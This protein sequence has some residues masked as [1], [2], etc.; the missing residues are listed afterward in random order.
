MNKDEA[1]AAAIAESNRTGQPAK[2]IISTPWQVTAGID[3]DHVQTLGRYS[4]CSTTAAIV[5]PGNPGQHAVELRQQPMGRVAHPREVA[6]AVAFLLSEEASF[7]TATTLT[8][9]NGMWAPALGDREK[10]PS[11]RAHSPLPPSPLPAPQERYVPTRFARRLNG[12]LTQRAQSHGTRLSNQALA[13]ALS[14]GGHRVSVPYL[15][16]LR[17]GRR[18]NPSP[19]LT[20]ALT[21]FFE[22]DPDYFEHEPTP[23][24]PSNNALIAALTTPG[25]RRLLTTAEGLSPAALHLLDH[26]A[27]TLQP[28]PL[29]RSNSA[30]PIDPRPTTLRPPGEPFRT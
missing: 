1:I 15:C 13:H 29:S 25:L 9:A 7:I 5:Q 4:L 28:R 2:V 27:G 23:D 3:N 20:A 8:V 22:V 14:E 17:R 24:Q 19:A 6:Q 12:L 21:R 26:L 11:A 18:E 10:T 16:Q 30:P